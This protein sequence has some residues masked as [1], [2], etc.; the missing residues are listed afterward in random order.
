[1]NMKSDDIIKKYATK[2][3]GEYVLTES[4]AKLAMEEYANDK[5][6]KIL[7]EYKNILYKARTSLNDEFFEYFSN[8]LNNV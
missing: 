4:A 2:Y 6:L 3:R 5:K 8:L 7:N 1:M